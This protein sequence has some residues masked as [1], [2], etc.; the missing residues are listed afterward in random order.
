VTGSCEHSNEPLCYIKGREF[1]EKLSD[2]YLLKKDCA[3]Q[4]EIG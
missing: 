3:S 2:Y 1:L 4:L